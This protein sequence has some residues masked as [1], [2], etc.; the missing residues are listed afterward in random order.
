[1]STLGT[2]PSI[3]SPELAKSLQH[4]HCTITIKEIQSTNK[5]IISVVMIKVRRISY[6]WTTEL[7]IVERQKLKCSLPLHCKI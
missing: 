4:T 3:K 1:M 7:M 5:I 2:F 6:H